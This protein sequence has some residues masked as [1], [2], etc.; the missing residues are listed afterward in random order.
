MTPTQKHA[1]KM[2]LESL[3]ELVADPEVD[4]GPSYGLMKE[5]QR[6]VI[7]ALRAA[8]KGEP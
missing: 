7:K 5:R 2:A 6:K 1:M 8:L 4:F 3:K